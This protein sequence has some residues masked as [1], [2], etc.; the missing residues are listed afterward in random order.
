MNLSGNNFHLSSTSPAI[1][2][3]SSDNISYIKF[4]KDNNSR[5]QGT[6]IDIG[7]D[8]SNG[9]QRMSQN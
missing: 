6:S 7:A 4:D 1:N 9:A 8:E 3:G 5:I 2:S